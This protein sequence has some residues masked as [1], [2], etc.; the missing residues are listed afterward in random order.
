MVSGFDDDP[1]S[2][3]EDTLDFLVRNNIGSV[4]FNI[5][6]PYPGT[7][8][9]RRLESEGRLLTRDWRWYDHC[10]LTYRT[11]NMTPGEFTK[12]FEDMVKG[13]YSYPSILKRLPGNR[14]HPFFFMAINMAKHWKSRKLG[15]ATVERADELGEG[16]N[17]DVGA[18]VDGL[19]PIS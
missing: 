18:I 19:D 13:F 1:E 2:V 8:V 6:T 3:F 10:T 14:H 7:E 16:P 11:K 17:D 5:L 12:K 9:Y 4:S 15:V